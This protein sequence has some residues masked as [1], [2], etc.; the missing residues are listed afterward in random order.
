MIDPCR[1]AV[2]DLPPNPFTSRVFENSGVILKMILEWRDLSISRWN[3]Y[4]VGWIL[5]RMRLDFGDISNETSYVCGRR[6]RVT[7]KIRLVLYVIRIWLYRCVTAIISS[8]L[9][10]RCIVIVDAMSLDIAASAELVWL[11]VGTLLKISFSAIVKSTTPGFGLVTWRE[12]REECG[13]WL[14]LEDG[15][16]RTCIHLSAK[17]SHSRYIRTN[18]IA[19]KRGERTENR[20]YCNKF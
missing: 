11:E 10:H 16:T 13:N 6:A 1:H 17:P 18:M 7:S 14:N 3:D 19:M 2:S 15:I 20:A 4:P 5:S 9:L 12:V 8:F